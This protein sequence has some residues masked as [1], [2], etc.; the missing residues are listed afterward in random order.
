MPIAADKRKSIRFERYHSGSVAHTRRERNTVTRLG[1]V[2][3]AEATIK[4]RKTVEKRKGEERYAAACAAA[5]P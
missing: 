3:Q 5:G 1:S 2:K 4:R